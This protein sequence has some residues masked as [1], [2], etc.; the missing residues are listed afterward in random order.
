MEL[1]GLGSS[2]LILYRIKKKK[3]NF[4][5]EEVDTELSSC[6]MWNSSVKWFIAGE[7]TADSLASQGNI[8]GVSCPQASH[9]IKLQV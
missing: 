6:H 8:Y 5:M 1:S 9:F 4:N 7:F 3:K 2:C